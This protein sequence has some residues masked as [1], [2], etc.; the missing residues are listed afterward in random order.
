M[1]RSFRYAMA[2]GCLCVGITSVLAGSAGAAA[3]DGQTLLQA[4][5]NL[6]QALSSGDR[7]AAGKLLE[8]GFTWTDSAGTT[9]TKA[10]VL[11]NP[12]TPAA[13]NDGDAQ[14]S[15]RIYGRVGVVRVDRGKAHAL[16]IWVRRAAGWHA[17]VVH[18][19]TQRENP[20]PASAPGPGSDV[21]DNPC[22]GIPYKP[23]TAAER[24]IIASWQQL[25]TAVT[26]HDADAWGPHFR[27]E[28][29]L[30][31]SNGVEPSTKAGRMATI[32]KQKE[33]GV[34]TA[35]SPLTAARMLNFGDTVV[36]LA[37]HQP[38]TGKPLR[39]SRVWVKGK[40]VWQMAISFQ[41]REEAATAITLQ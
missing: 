26:E 19:V 35:P 9:Q 10:D 13:A 7:K 41:T 31:S 28:F 23:K 24:G 8:P 39:V 14:I 3:R 27:D 22:K 16:R 32:R 17:L 21:C 4:D 6:L 25:E 15:E 38:R 40:N 37:R 33:A 36:M 18:E 5:R 30:I 1:E 20:A 12:P 34:G 2:L 29:V 11:K